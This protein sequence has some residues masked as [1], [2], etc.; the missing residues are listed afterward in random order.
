MVN[1]ICGCCTTV[2]LSLWEL[3]IVQIRPPFH[4]ITSLLGWHVIAQGLKNQLQVSMYLVGFKSYF[5]MYMCII[6]H[7][8][9]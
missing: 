6:S 8:L 7:V 3:V 5:D 2:P 4:C 1:F 9:F